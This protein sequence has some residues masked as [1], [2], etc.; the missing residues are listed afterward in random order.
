MSRFL[1]PALSLV[2]LCVGTGAFIITSIL[3]DVARALSVSLPAA[4]QAM[5]A[6]ALSTALLAPLLLVATGRWPRRHA[7]VFAMLLFALGNAVCALA[8][9]LPV[10]LAGRVLMGIGAVFTPLAA[11]LIVASVPPAQ[12]GKALALVFLGISLSYVIGLPLGSWLA[13]HQG[14]HAP[15]WVVVVA[16]LLSCLL[17]WAVV[18]KDVQAAGISTQGL[19]SLLARAEVL[20]VLCITLLYFI[21]IFAVFSYVVPV[22]QGLVPMSAERLSLTLL[23]FGL[24]GVAGTLIGGV[25]NDR[26]GALKSLSV[27]LVLL[28]SMMLALPLTQGNWIFMVG[29]MLLWGTAGFGMMAP[30][31]TRLAALSPA[32]APLLLSLNT[33]MLYLGTALGAV[34]GG[35]FVPSLGFTHLAW[36]GAPLAGLALLLLWLGPRVPRV[37]PEP[38]P[39][40][41]G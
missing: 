20:S 11:G 8:T 26:F 29:V 39:L 4:G 18:P 36:V 33:S 19:G 21:A 7:M 6:Y 35:V 41:A 34:L 31:Q 10:L 24:S 37:L 32:H 23:L 40:P 5:S 3:P 12:R 28:G 15:I 1:L 16:S 9:S 14:W 13:T 2:N 22:L 25:A 27:L 38:P 17:L 30:Q